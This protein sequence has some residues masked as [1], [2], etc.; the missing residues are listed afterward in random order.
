M[1]PAAAERDGRRMS[2]DIDNPPV[3]PPADCQHRLLWRLARALWEAH[4]PDS[5]GFCL[6]TPNQRDPCRLARL[7][8]EGMRTACGEAVSASPPWI[9]VTRERLTTGEID[10]MDAVAEALWH[11]RHTHRSGR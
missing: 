2:F 1:E 5:T 10:P 4:R 3:E 6:S 8:Q 7:A 9:A 11:R